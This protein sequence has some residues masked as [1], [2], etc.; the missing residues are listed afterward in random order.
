MLVLWV[1]ATFSKNVSVEK[2]F[3]SIRI[4]DPEDTFLSSHGDSKDLDRNFSN[5]LAEGTG[6]ESK[7]SDQSSSTENT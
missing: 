6:V 2:Y 1:L 4:G 5:E 3:Q 7:E